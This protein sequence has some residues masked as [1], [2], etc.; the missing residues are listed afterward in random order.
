MVSN[1]SQL[2]TSLPLEN[3]RYE[4]F[5]VLLHSH[6]PSQWV[7]RKLIFE[8]F[9]HSLNITIEYYNKT[10][11]SLVSQIWHEGKIKRRI[12]HSNSNGRGP[13]DSLERMYAQLRIEIAN[14]AKAA[15]PDVSRPL[16]FRNCSQATYSPGLLVLA[17]SAEGELLHSE[18]SERPHAGW[19]FSVYGRCYEESTKQW[20]SCGWTI[21][22]RPQDHE[23]QERDLLREVRMQRKEREGY[24]LDNREFC[25]ELYPRQLDE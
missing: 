5:Q 23:W 12:Y 21:R 2:F 4:I 20:C 8:K 9:T 19:A 16:F 18:T 13:S 25:P 11:I 15:G 24:M 7:V 14:W 3:T 6:I 17:R 22:C 10:T 1:E